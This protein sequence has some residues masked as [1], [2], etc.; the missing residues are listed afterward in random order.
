MAI[1][2][3]RFFLPRCVKLTSEISYHNSLSPGTQSSEEHHVC[4]LDNAIVFLRAR[5]YHLQRL[6][7]ASWG[8]EESPVCVA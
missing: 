6:S 2:Q 4:L 1:L 8:I 7:L 3:L 5:T